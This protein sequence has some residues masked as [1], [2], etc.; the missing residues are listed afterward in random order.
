MALSDGEI[1]NGQITRVRA[2]RGEQAR[3]GVV[4]DSYQAPHRPR[5]DPSA[6]RVK[7][8]IRVHPD[9]IRRIAEEATRTGDSSGVVVDRLAAAIRANPHTLRLSQR[10]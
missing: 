7:W 6:A 8:S 5:R 9:T 4:I 2:A 1:W 10:G 3:E